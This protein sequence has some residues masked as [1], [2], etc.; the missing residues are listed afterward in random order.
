[1]YLLVCQDQ[2]SCT[3]ETC[4]RLSYPTLLSVKQEKRVW[5]GHQSFQSFHRLAVG[6]KEATIVIVQVCIKKLYDH[7]PL[8]KLIYVC[9]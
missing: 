9:T 3:L 8:H 5:E 7:L 1:M 6:R 4:Q 2:Q